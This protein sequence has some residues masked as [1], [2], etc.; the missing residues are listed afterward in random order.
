M[1]FI[2]GMFSAGVA[3]EADFPTVEGTNIT[4]TSNN[5]TSRT[6]NLPTGIVAGDL[7]MV[8]AMGATTGANLVMSGWSTLYNTTFQSDGTSAVFYKTAVGSDTSTM[9]S[10]NVKVC[11]TAYRISG[12]TGTPE[13]ASA[14]HG[15]SNS[16]DPDSLTPSWGKTNTLWIAAA[17]QSMNSGT[18]SSY[19]SSYT[20]GVNGVASD[21]SGGTMGSAHRQ[22]RAVSENPGAFTMS[23]SNNWAARTVAI[24]PG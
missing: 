16:P 1:S 18:V 15:N 22:L 19:P 4:S 13:A 8:F 10:A 3:I 20:G 17:H 14:A 11:A 9:T 24:R 2:P 5:A 21:A 12:W 6:I 7:L 23:G